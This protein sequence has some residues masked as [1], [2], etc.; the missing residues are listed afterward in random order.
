ICFPSHSLELHPDV[1][2]PRITF[3]NPNRDCHT[4]CD[5]ILIREDSSYDSGIKS[6][7]GISATNMFLRLGSFS[8]LKAVWGCGVCVTDSMKDGSITVHAIDD[9]G[10]VRD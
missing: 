2:A 7:Q 3:V 1:T 8:P 4:Q 9:S 10:N 6:I 5:S